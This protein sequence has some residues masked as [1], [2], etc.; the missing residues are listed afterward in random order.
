MLLVLLLQWL[1]GND[2]IKGLLRIQAL[3]FRSKKFFP[4]MDSRPH[5]CSMMVH[6]R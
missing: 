3:E 5:I 1:K 2:E 6:E 4:K